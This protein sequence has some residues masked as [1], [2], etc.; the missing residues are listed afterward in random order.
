M[1]NKL[2]NLI[3]KNN[4]LKELSF[5][6][7]YLPGVNHIYRKIYAWN[8][9]R[10]LADFKLSD[11]IISIEPTNVCNSKCAMCPYQ[12]MTRPKE[13]MAMDLFKKIVDDC[14]K[15]G[16]EKFNLNFYNEPFL[17]L[18]IFK[19]ISYL[20]SNGLK[21]KLY[22]NGSIVDAEKTEKI[23]KSGLDEIIFSV[24]GA[25][26]ETYEKIR[27]GLDFNATVSNILRL[28]KRKNESGLKTPRI[29]VAF[30]RQDINKNEV[31]DFQEF[32][33]D[34]ADKTIIAF[35]DNR[36]ETSPF[37]K[38]G[39][40][41]LTAFPCK[42]LWTELVVMSNGKIPLCCIDCDGKVILGDFKTQTLAE[43][44]NSAGFKKIRDWHLNFKSGWIALC[45]NC[46]HSYRMNLRSWW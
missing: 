21:V 31:K 46:V 26:K 20:K 25:K 10:K 27:I 9:S 6:S 17:D 14:V 44:W 42:K 38:N 35:D 30:V 45:R 15:N 12:K 32:W 1:K 36:N 4:F 29:L 28:I 11:L 41:N 24:D 23:L 40:I 22:S 5:E 18:L 2:L 34:K 8:I 13:T 7:I 37:F 19:R 16:I 39:M 43:I 3:A 33:E